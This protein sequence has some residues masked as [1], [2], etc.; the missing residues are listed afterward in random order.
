[1]ILYALK[2]K[3]SGLW[4]GTLNEFETIFPEEEAGIELSLSESL[5][6]MLAYCPKDLNFE[7]AINRWEFDLVKV[8]II[9]VQEEVEPRNHICG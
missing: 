4:A 5:V 9:E 6:P 7:E 1:M 8:K 2:H 3:G